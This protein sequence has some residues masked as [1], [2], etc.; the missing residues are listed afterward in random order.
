MH[1]LERLHSWLQCIRQQDILN[2]YGD[3]ALQCN[4]MFS[5]DENLAKLSITTR[6]VFSSVTFFS[7]KIILTDVDPPKSKK[8]I[9]LWQDWFCFSFLLCRAFFL[10]G[11]QMLALLLF[12]SQPLAL[13]ED[14]QV[15]NHCN[16]TGNSYHKILIYNKNIKF[17]LTGFFKLN[18]TITK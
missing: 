6:A 8:C 16:T 7:K 18:F 1:W 2:K 4:T 13:V 12:S 14:S 5:M 9:N 3:P 15:L 10:R 11:E 17:C